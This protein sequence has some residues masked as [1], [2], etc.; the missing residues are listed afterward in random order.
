MPGFPSSP[1]HRP[2]KALDVWL[3]AAS[4]L[5]G[6][7]AAAAKP[8]RQDEQ[9][10][11]DDAHD[12]STYRIGFRVV[13]QVARTAP[14]QSRTSAINTSGSSESRLRCIDRVHDPGR[15]ESVTRHQA[16]KPVPWHI[17][18]GPRSPME[19]FPPDPPDPLHNLLQPQA[20]TCDAVGGK[21]AQ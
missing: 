4:W 15:G 16:Q 12:E 11:E 9:Q 17:G 8:A 5:R 2:L 20:M 13:P 10:N 1:L 7:L 21:V 19:P 18:R 14:P 6:A 3:L